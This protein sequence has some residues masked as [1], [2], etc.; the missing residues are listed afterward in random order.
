MARDGYQYLC[1]ADKEWH[2]ARAESYIPYDRFCL[3]YKPIYIGNKRQDDMPQLWQPHWSTT[4][5]DYKQWEYSCVELWRTYMTLQKIKG[6]HAIDWC[7]TYGLSSWML[8]H[9]HD[10]V[11]TLECNEY[12]M[13]TAKRNLKLLKQD[14]YEQ[15][16]IEIDCDKHTAVAR[17]VEQDWTPYDTIRLGSS[18]YKDIYRAIRPQLDNCRLLTTAV[19]DPDFS[20]ELIM[21]DW[22]A[23]PTAGRSR[24]EIFERI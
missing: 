3:V 21:D 14:F 23:L 19:Y 24:A 4:T 11:T 16:F 1:E 22:R 9:G 6:S 10:T 13:H 5:I 20:N 12:I 15:R 17:A 2:Q 7:S 18:N 8:G